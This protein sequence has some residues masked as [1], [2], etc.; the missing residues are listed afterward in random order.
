[1]ALLGI[2]FKPETD[3]IREAPAVDIAR[4]LLERGARVRAYDPQAMEIARPELPDVEMC[5]DAYEA[6]RGADALVLVTEWNQFRMLDLDRVKELLRRPVIV[7]LRNVY[8]PDPMRERGFV[9]V[10]VGR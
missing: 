1:M 3:D 4:G 10:G 7:D 2:S 9:Y 6:C 5:D 8:D